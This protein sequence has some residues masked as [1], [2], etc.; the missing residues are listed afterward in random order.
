MSGYPI[1]WFVWMCVSEYDEIIEKTCSVDCPWL[2]LYPLT[3]RIMP[4][5]IIARNVSPEMEISWNLGRL[6]I[7]SLFRN[8]F[9]QGGNVKKN[10]SFL[11]MIIKVQMGRSPDGLPFEIGLIIE[12]INYKILGIALNY[13]QHE[14]GENIGKWNNKHHGQ[15][16]D[17]PW[18]GNIREIT[19]SKEKRHLPHWFS[20]LFFLKPTSKLRDY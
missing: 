19:E 5:W 3:F 4:K 10:D 6:L 16:S 12:R 18:E 20:L 1:T 11:L 13:V 17:Y 15:G 8:L 14:D 2:S 9:W 7:A